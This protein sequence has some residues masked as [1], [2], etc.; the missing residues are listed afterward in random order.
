LTFNVAGGRNKCHPPTQLE[1][2]R[3]HEHGQ[4]EQEGSSEAVNQLQHG[5]FR[6][7]KLVLALPARPDLEQVS[8]SMYVCGSNSQ[9]L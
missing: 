9:G 6:V 4:E 1:R 3:E 5:R 7:G 2:Q 8:I